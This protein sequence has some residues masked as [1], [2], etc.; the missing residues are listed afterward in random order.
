MARSEGSERPKRDA[1]VSRE[2]SQMRRRLPF[3]LMSV[4]AASLALG[5]FF[6]SNAANMS[7]CDVSQ[8]QDMSNAAYEIGL[9]GPAVTHP[10]ES[11]TPA[12]E[13]SDSVAATRVAGGFIAII[14]GGLG[15]VGAYE[16]R[17]R[18]IA[19]ASEVERLC[20]TAIE[21]GIHSGGDFG[22]GEAPREAL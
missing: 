3:A 5:G 8:E 10:S 1:W 12:Q 19:F 15:A 20:T 4:G 11:P 9:P 6:I 13:C 14:G 7:G 18:P 17:R 16:Y 2:L 22:F 21:Q